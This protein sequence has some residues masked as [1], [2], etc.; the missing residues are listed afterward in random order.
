MFEQL[1]PA[2]PGLERRLVSKPGLTGLAQVSSG[3][4]NDVSGARRKLAYDLRYLRRRG[5][6]AEIRLVLATVPKVWDRTA[7]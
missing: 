5:I 6:L 3:Y 7:L 1:R 4:S 2:M